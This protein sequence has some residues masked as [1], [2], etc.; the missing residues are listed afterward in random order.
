MNQTQTGGGI[1]EDKYGVMMVPKGSILYSSGSKP[2]GVPAD[3]PM[4]FM[5]F[6]PSDW[7]STYIQRITLKRDVFVLFMVN[8]ERTT[9]HIRIMSALPE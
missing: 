1:L 9:H 8:L 5:T 6:H 2:T 4:I 3:K 7:S